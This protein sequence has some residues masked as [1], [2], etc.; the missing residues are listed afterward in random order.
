MRCLAQ[1][2]VRDDPPRC[3]GWQTLSRKKSNIRPLLAARVGTVRRAP[4]ASDPIHS[5]V[6]L[7]IDLGSREWGGEHASDCATIDTAALDAS[8]EHLEMIAKAIQR[9]DD[10]L[11]DVLALLADLA[12]ILNAPDS[13]RG[14]VTFGASVRQ[15]HVDGILESIDHLVEGLRFG[16]SRLFDGRFV[17][18]LERLSDGGC[19]S[20]RLPSL[21]TRALGDGAAG[22]LSLLSGDRPGGSAKVNLETARVI[23]G[24]AAEQVRQ[25]R[26]RVATFAEETVMQALTSLRIAQ[27]N[28]SATNRAAEDVEFAVRASRVTAVDALLSRSEAAGSA[29]CA[30]EPGPFRVTDA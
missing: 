26:Q 14:G 30:G 21:E 28:V 20:E 15:V 6:V 16:G 8:I 25:S 1:R 19:A 4:T 5:N 18:E 23:A 7:R 2:V 22:T 11:A 29:D 3:Q 17:M 9:A 24:R 27:E 12:E 10:G 13:S